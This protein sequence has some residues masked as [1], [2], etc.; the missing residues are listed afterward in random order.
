VAYEAIAN[1]LKHADARVASVHVTDLGDRVRVT[2]HDDGV[3]GANIGGGTGL[4][5][6]RARVNAVD[7]AVSIASPVGGP[8]TVVAEVPR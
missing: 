7:G 3:G 6:M 8:T 5:G 2:V 4:A 1:V